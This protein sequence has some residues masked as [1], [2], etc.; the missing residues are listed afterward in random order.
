MK[1]IIYFSFFTAVIISLVSPASYADYYYSAGIGDGGDAK[2]NSFTIEAGNYSN[3]T[4][5]RNYLFA[6]SVPLIDH[7][8]IKTPVEI[9]DAPSPHNDVTGLGEK[10]DGLETGLLGKAGMGLWKGKLFLTLTGGL[11]QSNVVDV[12]RSNVGEHY[13]EQSNERKIY[14]VYGSGISYFHEFFDWGLKMNFQI[15]Y[16][17]RRGVTGFIGWN[18]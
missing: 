5:K 1:L 18:W 10:N 8:D 3:S 17:N 15:D 13:Y 11:T 9:I 16:D 2:T 12:V 14:G 7:G 6:V 4:D